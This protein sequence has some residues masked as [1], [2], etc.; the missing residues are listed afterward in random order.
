MSLLNGAKNSFRYR[1][2]KYASPT[3]FRASQR[4]TK[5]TRNIRLE[6]PGDRFIFNLIYAGTLESFSKRFK[7]S[8]EIVRKQSIFW[9]CNDLILTWR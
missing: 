9:A 8:F 3:G 2:Y 6:S 1:F 4:R 7:L 5:T